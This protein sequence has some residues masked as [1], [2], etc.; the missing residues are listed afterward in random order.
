MSLLAKTG[1]GNY[2]QIKSYAQAKSVL[3]NEIK[4]NSRKKK[5]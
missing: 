3:M 1:N 2:I 4:N 5:H